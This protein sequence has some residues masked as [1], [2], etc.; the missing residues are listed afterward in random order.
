MLLKQVAQQYCLDPLVLADQSGQ[1]WSGTGVDSEAVEL[2]HSVAGLEP[3]TNQD[4][5]CW[6]Q[7]DRGAVLLKQVD[8]AGTTLY[9]AAR[10]PQRDAWLALKHASFGVKRILGPL[11]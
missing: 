5:F 3:L 2:A 9:L 8:V 10:G 7:Q 4:G 6:I 11:C 1:L